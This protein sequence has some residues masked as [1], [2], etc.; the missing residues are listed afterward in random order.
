MQSRIRLC[1]NPP[2]AFD[3]PQCEG[4]DSQTQV[5]KERPCPGEGSGTKIRFKIFVISIRLFPSGESLLKSGFKVTD[6]PASSFLVPSSGWEVVILGG[7]GSL[8]CFVWRGDQTED[9]PLCQPRPSAWWQAVW[10]QRRAHWLLQQ[11]PLPQWVILTFISSHW[12]DFILF[13]SLSTVH[14][15]VFPVTY[16]LLWFISFPFL[17][18]T[19]FWLLFCQSAVTG[20]HGVAGGAAARHATVVKWGATG[21]VTTPD[22]P[23]VGEHVQVQIHRYRDA[24][25]PTVLVSQRA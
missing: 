5:C 23:M 2:P 14:L 17:S 19:F 22:L 8:R 21:H 6:A 16:L 3:G 12:L 20:V 4:S 11:R 10:R 7:L 1:N 15:S 9:T 13:I 25:Q 24:A 18:L